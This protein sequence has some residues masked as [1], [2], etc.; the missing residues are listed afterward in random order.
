MNSPIKPPG[1]TPFSQ[2]PE[3]V[4]DVT[5]TEKPAET[6]REVLD[7]L[8]PVGEVSNAKE[9]SLD[10][11]QAIADQLRT[12]KIDTSTALDRLVENALEDLSVGA[13]PPEEKLELQKMLRVALQ[14]DPT[15]AALTKDLR[16]QEPIEK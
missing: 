5:G 1:G 16:R 3:P 6:F 12:G 11:V 7:E 2:S 8:A 13:L 15:L 4:A 14:D 10:S 9:A